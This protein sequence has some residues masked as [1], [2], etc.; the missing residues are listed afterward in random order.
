MTAG[1]D[2]ETGTIARKAQ[3]MEEARKRRSD[4]PWY[5]LG[6]FGLVGWSVAVPTVA[7]TALGIW[8]DGRWPGEVSWTLTLL[9]GGAILGA[10]NAWYWVQREGRDD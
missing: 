1:R 10:L 3:R 4:S 6:M 8:I 2:D 5:G 9:V 7:G